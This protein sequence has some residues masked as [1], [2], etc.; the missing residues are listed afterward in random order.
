MINT[1]LLLLLLANRWRK[2][3]WMM[4]VVSMMSSTMIVELVFFVECFVA[5][6]A[7]KIANTRMYPSDMPIK[8]SFLDKCRAA[9]MT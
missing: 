9:K 5:I 6:L 7:R 2:R 3:T 4:M 1:F 8:M